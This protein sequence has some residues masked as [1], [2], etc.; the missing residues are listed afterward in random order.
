MNV[1]DDK[2]IDDM[3]LLS[4]ACF[5]TISSQETAKQFLQ[6]LS[7]LVFFEFYEFP[8]IVNLI[9]NMPLGL[10][11]FINSFFLKAI[12]F[13]ILYGLSNPEDRVSRSAETFLLSLSAGVEIAN[14]FDTIKRA[15]N[16][17]HCENKLF[18][19]ISPVYI[20]NTF[21]IYIFQKLTY[22]AGFSQNMGTKPDLS[23]PLPLYRIFESNSGFDNNIDA[24]ST[25]RVLEICPDI[26][27][28]PFEFSVS[29]DPMQFINESYFRFGT[30]EKNLEK[31]IIFE[32]ASSN[33]QI[34]NSFLSTEK[35]PE[36]FLIEIKDKSSLLGQLA[37]S[38]DSM[39]NMFC[40][41]SKSVKALHNQ[42]IFEVMQCEIPNNVYTDSVAASEIISKILDEAKAILSEKKRSIDIDS[43]LVYYFQKLNI[44]TFIQ[45]QKEKL[46]ID[47]NELD[48]AEI[49]LMN[50]DMRYLEY[51]TIM[52][53]K[54]LFEPIIR[55]INIAFSGVP[56]SQLISNL[57]T[58]YY[59]IHQAFNEANPKCLKEYDGQII[60]AKVLLSLAKPKYFMS[61]ILFIHQLYFLPLEVTHFTSNNLSE[62]DRFRPFFDV[63]VINKEKL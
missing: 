27:I 59:N 6:S 40:K 58:I 23:K 1:Y 4:G 60:S 3:I 54:A 63:A 12:K 55:K 51:Q 35:I 49:I 20:M 50:E 36:K 11:I 47:M 37:K 22:I 41:T 18:N 31:D 34:R 14:F 2:I 9:L 57:K 62:I 15:S 5:S 61:R 16:K 38:C 42:I 13:P 43:V 52:E 19:K 29:S 33:S 45:E 25:N 8:S 30:Y 53:N 26:Q 17:Q 44:E 24:Q 7:N 48:K 39:I 10:K 56:F 28:D 46:N 21:D 32:L